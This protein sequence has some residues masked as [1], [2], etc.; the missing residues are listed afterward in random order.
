MQVVRGGIGL[1]ITVAFPSVQLYLVGR[2][3]M[4]DTIGAPSSR[5]LRYIP[6]GLQPALNPRP[7]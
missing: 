2:L 7:P 1:S 3:E 4:R 6:G 5:T